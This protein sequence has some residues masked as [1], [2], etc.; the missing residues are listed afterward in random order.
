MFDVLG[1]ARGQTLSQK[2][3]T[4]VALQ[5]LKPGFSANSLHGKPMVEAMSRIFFSANNHLH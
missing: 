5:S 4:N 1:L 3:K 2:T